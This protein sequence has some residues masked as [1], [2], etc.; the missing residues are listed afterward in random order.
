[1]DRTGHSTCTLIR[2][3][4]FRVELRFRQTE[5]IK[6]CVTH[7]RCNGTLLLAPQGLGRVVS[8]AKKEAESGFRR[9]EL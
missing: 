4:I 2:I 7:K 8:E 1:M 6:E 3:K 9:A 5:W